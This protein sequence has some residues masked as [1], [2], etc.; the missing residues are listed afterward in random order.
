MEF[1]LPPTEKP[2][3]PSCAS[4]ALFAKS[5]CLGI[6]TVRAVIGTTQ[7][8]EGAAITGS[9]IDLSP[10]KDRAVKRSFRILQKTLRYCPGPGND[11]RG[12]F[13]RSDDTF[14]GYFSA[15]IVRVALDRVTQQFASN[16]LEVLTVFSH[17]FIPSEEPREDNTSGQRA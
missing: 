16:D 17:S 7:A 14:S 4:C 10:F 6:S 15:V 1:I 9:G 11:G 8:V 5:E 13:R 3:G 12:D 2:F